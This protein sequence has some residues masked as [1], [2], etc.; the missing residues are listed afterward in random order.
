MSWHKAGIGGESILASLMCTINEVHVHVCWTQTWRYP[1]E[2]QSLQQIL[3][4]SS[5]AA[6]KVHSIGIGTIKKHRIHGLKWY[7]C[8]RTYTCTSVCITSLMK[9]SNVNISQNSK[10]PTFISSTQNSNS[11]RNNGHRGLESERKLSIYK[12]QNSLKNASNVW[13]HGIQRLWSFQ[14]R[15][16]CF[17]Q[18]FSTDQ[19]LQRAFSAAIPQHHQNQLEFHVKIFSRLRVDIHYFWSVCP[20][21]KHYQP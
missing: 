15:L 21:H 9:C 1:N 3:V 11:G 5:Y 10:N 12:Q 13:M 20:G 7:E 17:F 19:A 14:L 6:R 16:S 8:N 18:L 4:T 2:A